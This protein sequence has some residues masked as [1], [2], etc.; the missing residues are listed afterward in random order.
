MTN[1]MNIGIWKRMLKAFKGKITESE[2]ISIIDKYEHTEEQII[3][4]KKIKLVLKDI[5][6]I[7]NDQYF[8]KWK[9]KK[10]SKLPK[11][12]EDN[13]LDTKIIT[14]VWRG[15]N[16]KRSAFL[17]VVRMQENAF[18]IGN[19]RVYLTGN[20]N[21][22]YCRFCDNQIMTIPH[23]LLTCC[24]TKKLQKDM[25]KYVKKYTIVIKD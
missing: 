6:T 22:K 19:K 8:Q 3:K 9:D 4:K 5:Q 21:S 1:D 18:M 15:L 12:L 24:I 11:L 2:I 10:S 25:M 14:K 7:L 13:H 16:I 17:Q 23:L 20:S